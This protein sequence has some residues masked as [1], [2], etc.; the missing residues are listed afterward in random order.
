MT[1]KMKIR[2]LT[3]FFLVAVFLSAKGQEDLFKDFAEA[4]KERAFCFYPS[5]LR[6]LNIGGNEEFDQMVKGVEKLL[7]YKLDSASRN[8]KAYK[9]MVKEF[10]SEGFEEYL[11]ITGGN[12]EA[13][14]LASPGNK[15]KEYVGYFN[16]EDALLAFYLKGGLDWDE[17]PKLINGIKEGDFINILDLN[18]SGFENHP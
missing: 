14:L 18:T 8:G 7:V 16:Q 10:K 12:Y 2:V 3:V 1:K 5:T 11:S 6:M 9:N 17:L 13:S 15:G 4:H